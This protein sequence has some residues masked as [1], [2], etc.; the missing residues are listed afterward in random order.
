VINP[1][2]QGE[3]KITVIAT[4]FDRGRAPQHRPAPDGPRPVRSTAADDPFQP[5]SGPRQAPRERPLVFDEE[6][7]LDTPAFLRRRPPR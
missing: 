2:L 4:G 6:D 3:M 1:E 7:D 5:R